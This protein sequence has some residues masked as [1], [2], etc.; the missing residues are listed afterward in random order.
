LCLLRCDPH[1]WLHKI[2]LVSDDDAAEA[3]DIFI[4]NWSLLF[5]L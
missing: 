2:L 1:A 5:E 3:V 4:I